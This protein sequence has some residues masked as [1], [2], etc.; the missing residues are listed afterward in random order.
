MLRIYVE[1]ALRGFLTA[2]SVSFALWVL[3]VV[4]G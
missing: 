2:L 4:F 1:E 3:I